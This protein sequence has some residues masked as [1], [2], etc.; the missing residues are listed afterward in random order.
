MLSVGYLK[1]SAALRH[2]TFAVRFAMRERH[3]ENGLERSLSAS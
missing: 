2:V 1:D 3:F